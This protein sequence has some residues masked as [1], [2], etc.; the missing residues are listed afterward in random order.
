MEDNT[1]TIINKG[2]SH[3][4]MLASLLTNEALNDVKLKGTDGVEVPA[5]RFLLAARSHIFRAMF[6]SEFQEAK[7]PVV[8]LG[9]QGNVL[10]AVVEYIVTDS[11]EIIT[12]AR[13]RKS[14]DDTEPPYDFSKRLSL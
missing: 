9:F 8:E 13:K 7:S 12:A 3:R 1:T 10:Q 2:I 4:E 14:T 6:F 11:A 5:S